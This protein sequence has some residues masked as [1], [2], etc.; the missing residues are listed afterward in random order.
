MGNA[1]FRQGDLRMST[2]SLVDLLPG[3]M[4]AVPMLSSILGSL[5]TGGLRQM[6]TDVLKTLTQQITGAIPGLEELLTTKE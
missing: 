5:K 3:V 1:F 2:D 6:D 4:E